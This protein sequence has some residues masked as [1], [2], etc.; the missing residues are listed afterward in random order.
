MFGV[1]AVYQMSN[2]DVGKTVKKSGY[3]HDGTNHSC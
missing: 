2:Q 3:Q 1:G